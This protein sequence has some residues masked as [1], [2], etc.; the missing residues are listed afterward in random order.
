MEGTLTA[1]NENIT[2]EII[3]INRKRKFSQMSQTENMQQ[4]NDKYWAQ[5]G[6]NR[7]LE[8]EIARMEIELS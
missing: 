5:L 8:F 1:Q 6:K 4:L 3:D 2:N 7:E